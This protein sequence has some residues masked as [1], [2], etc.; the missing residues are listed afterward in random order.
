MSCGARK[1]KKILSVSAIASI[2]AVLDYITKKLV[3]THVHPSEIIDVLPFLRIVNVKNTGAAFGM[4]S[5]LS[6]RIFIA[7]TVIAII[8]ILIYL[9]RSLKKLEIISLSF[10]LGGAIGN[11]IDRVNIGKVIDFIDF[12]VN[13]WHWPAF[14]VADSSLTVGIILFIWTNII[15]REHHNETQINADDK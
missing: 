7:L 2:I 15:H 9:S 12:F 10:I 11:L 4:F 5:S 6:N 14:N 8:L 1:L 13:D 3:E